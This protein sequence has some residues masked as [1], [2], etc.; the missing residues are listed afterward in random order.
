VM[1]PSKMSPALVKKIE[2]DLRTVILSDAYKDAMG[3]MGNV[4]R[5]EGQ[6]QFSKTL[7]DTYNRNKEALSSK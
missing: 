5:F 4:A 6:E 1:G 3:K 2:G 7:K